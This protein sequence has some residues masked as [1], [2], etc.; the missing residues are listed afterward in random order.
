MLFEVWSEYVDSGRPENCI[1]TYE[2]AAFTST[3]DNVDAVMSARLELVC[4]WWDVRTYR[5]LDYITIKRKR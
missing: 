3:Q 2:L 5:I 4:M 1:L